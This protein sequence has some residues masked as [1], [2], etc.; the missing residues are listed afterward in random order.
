MNNIITIKKLCEQELAFLYEYIEFCKNRS[1][2]F[3]DNDTNA[4]NLVLEFSSH[5][6]N[7]VELVKIKKEFLKKID[8]YL[9]NNCEHKWVND[10]ID[11][12]PDTSKEISYCCKCEYINNV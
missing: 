2:F 9:Y 8:N 7:A 6:M 3:A 1:F 5:G 12:D 11:I 4:N 10:L